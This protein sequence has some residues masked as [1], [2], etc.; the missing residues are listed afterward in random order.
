[1]R[2]G[3]ESG[4]QP[5]ARSLAA[6]HVTAWSGDVSE[7]RVGL[8]AELHVRVSESLLLCGI[9]LVVAFSGRGIRLDPVS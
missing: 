6:L 8:L 2:R 9:P 4:T 3:I 7:P 1:M 5:G